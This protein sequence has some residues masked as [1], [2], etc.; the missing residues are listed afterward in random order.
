MVVHAPLVVAPEEVFA[1]VV[2]QV[3]PVAVHVVGPALRV[4][5][6][7]DR[8]DHGP[9]ARVWSEEPVLPLAVDVGGWDQASQALQQFERREQ[10]RGAALQ[11]RLGEPV[12]EARVGREERLLPAER[13]EAFERE[14]PARAT[15]S[16]RRCPRTR[17]SM[18]A[19][20]SPSTRTEASTL[21]PRL[22]LRSAVS[23]M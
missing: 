1:E 23:Y 9:Q 12:E 20:S 6:L 19:R 7:A 22:P 2:R 10:E 13:E 17:R 3:P 15:N 14:G 18:P 8:H 16:S 4:V 11:V 21:K 5:E